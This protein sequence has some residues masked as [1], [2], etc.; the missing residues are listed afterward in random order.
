[1]ID[2]SPDLD[3][4]KALPISPALEEDPETEQ[5]SANGYYEVDPVEHL[6]D[7]GSLDGPFRSFGAM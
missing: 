6:S 4:L 3:C 7:S 2:E 1:L 5:D